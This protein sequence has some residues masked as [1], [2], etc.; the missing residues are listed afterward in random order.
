MPECGLV[1]KNVEASWLWLSS[2]SSLF[3]VFFLSVMSEDLKPVIEW[4]K[5]QFFSGISLFFVTNLVVGKPMQCIR[6][7]TS[8]VAYIYIF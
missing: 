5:K 3:K 7:I 2:V 4:C 1:N 6:Y 8:L